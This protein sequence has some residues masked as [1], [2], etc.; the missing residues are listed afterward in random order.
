VQKVYQLFRADADGL[1][2][3]EQN[4]ATP[5]FSVN[6]R[7]NLR[8]LADGYYYVAGLLALCGLAYGLWRRESWALF[9]GLILGYWV[10][11]HVAFY[12]EP[13]LHVPVQPLIALLASVLP[14]YVVSSRR[15]ES[16]V[17]A[18]ITD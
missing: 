2:W 17:A 16:A 6:Q 4:G 15:P 10:L 8:R 3:N 14:A 5:I 11:V 1:L 12:G 7:D 18:A 9:C 13:R